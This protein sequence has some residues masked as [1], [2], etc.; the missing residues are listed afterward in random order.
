MTI[1]FIRLRSRGSSLRMIKSPV[2]FLFINFPDPPEKPGASPIPFFYAARR[3]FSGLPGW[4]TPAPAEPDPNTSKEIDTREGGR[5]VPGH[6]D[7]PK[8]PLRGPNTAFANCQDILR[9]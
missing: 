8:M 2:G 9:A 7:A 3:H 1:F 5:K 4:G 6:W